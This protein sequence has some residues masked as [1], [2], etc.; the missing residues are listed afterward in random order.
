MSLIIFSDPKIQNVGTLFCYY[1]FGK[2]FMHIVYL[3]GTLL[4]VRSL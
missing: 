2:L 3:V 1:L 4:F